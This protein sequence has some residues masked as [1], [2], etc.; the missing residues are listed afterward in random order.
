[1]AGS[2]LSSAGIVRLMQ[3]VQLCGLPPLVV[4][5]SLPGKV[6]SARRNVG[7]GLAMLRKNL[8]AS[9][10]RCRGYPQWGAVSGVDESW[11]AKLSI[12]SGDCSAGI[13][14]LSR[15]PMMHVNVQMSEIESTCGSAPPS[16][17]PTVGWS[18]P[19]P[20]IMR[21]ATEAP[22]RASPRAA[23]LFRSP[24]RYRCRVLLNFYLHRRHKT[25][26]SQCPT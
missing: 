12:G 14:V 17:S 26:V 18:G 5:S 22:T 24:C 10:P 15:R 19:R 8:D 20:C 21:T 7:G 13:L 9:V 23:A 11:A 1:M 25:Q 4:L 6:L 3:C 2:P 16:K